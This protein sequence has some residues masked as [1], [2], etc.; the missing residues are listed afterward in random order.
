[1]AIP[2]E[3]DLA[4]LGPWRAGTDNLSLE[5]QV[6]R[7]S[8]RKAVNVDITDSGRVMRRHGRIKVF[9]GETSNIEGFGNRG[10]FQEGQVLYAFERV[11]GAETAAVP[12]YEGLRPEARL[13]YCLIEP[14]IYV[15]DGE[16]SLRISPS[17][18]VT[19]WSLPIPPLPGL[20]T[21]SG[22]LS[23]GRYHVAYAYKASSGEESP[24][25]NSAV[26]EIEDGQGV[27]VQLTH[28][29]NGMRT[30]IYM[31]KANGTELLHVA[32]V[33]GQPSSVNVHKQN[34]G[35][36]PATEDMDP[37]PG[38]E[39]AAVWNGR[40]LVA[41]DR[42]VQWSEPMQYGLTKSMYNYL[43]L[44]EA[45]TALGA[46]ETA[47]G[48]FIGQ[49]S[50]TYFAAGRDPADAQLREVY[51]AGIVPGTLHMVP[52]ARLAMDA[53]PAEPVPMWLATNGVFCVGMPT[54]D[55]VPM[56]EARF[57]AMKASDGAAFFDQ[58]DG[59]NRFVATLRNPTENNFAVSDTFSAEVIRNNLNP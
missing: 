15:S 25:S 52:G 31:T 24:L 46:P 40:L 59:I 50:R 51:P 49:Q 14:D 21:T 43:E 29:L 44:A 26:I 30:A 39:F 18:E 48:F 45:V 17:N 1:M 23:A 36:P 38:G 7:G 35:R 6:P 47:E 12:I 53:P 9:D 2:T 11:D 4:R 32:T 34:L 8:L 13:T 41:S 42:F 3:R 10:F 19:S 5:T 33:P 37:M 20:S 54:G 27:T 58:R 16:V 55:V 22:N 56:T 28:L 57:A